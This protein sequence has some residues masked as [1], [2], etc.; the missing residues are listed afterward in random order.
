MVNGRTLLTYR[1]DSMTAE[2]EVVSFVPLGVLPFHCLVFSEQIMLSDDSSD[3]HT[4]ME[5]EINHC[6]AAAYCRHNN[7]NLSTFCTRR[8]Y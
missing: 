1:I 3:L 8:I 2:L 5:D 7:F 4:S 6:V